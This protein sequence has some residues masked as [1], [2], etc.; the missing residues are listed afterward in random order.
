MP[1]DYH[2]LIV[3]A[4]RNGGFYIESRK[5]IATKNAITK[6]A[7]IIIRMANQETPLSSKN[8]SPEINTP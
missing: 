1:T 4:A 5:N 7:L 3:K 2:T 8:L 6:R